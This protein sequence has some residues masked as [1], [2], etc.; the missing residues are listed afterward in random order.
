MNLDALVWRPTNT[1]LEKLY[2]SRATMTASTLVSLL[3][4][5]GSDFATSSIVDLDLR[6]VELADSTWATVFEHLSPSPALE[7]IYVADVCYDRNGKSAHLVTDEG[8]MW[9]ECRVIWSEKE[10]DSRSLRDLLRMVAARGGDVGGVLDELEDG[11][12]D[13]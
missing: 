8:L 9:D 3:S 12:D 13:D 10:Q 11:M 2:L 7:S 6:R 5:C 4:P 1:G